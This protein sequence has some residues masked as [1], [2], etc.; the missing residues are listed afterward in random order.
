MI[1]LLLSS[2]GLWEYLCPVSS[3]SD[4]PLPTWLP[5]HLAGD[6]AYYTSWVYREEDFIDIG[7]LFL[8]K[9]C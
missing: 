3:L 9:G 1:Y 7:V 5:T 8:K 4:L 2:L 6:L